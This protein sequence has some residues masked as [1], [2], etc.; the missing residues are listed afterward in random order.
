MK[1]IY[2]KGMHC[3]ACKKLVQMELEENGLLK[4]ISSL[5]L[6]PDNTGKLNITEGV[7]AQEKEKIERVINNMETYKTL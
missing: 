5:E 1:E 3:D 4:N 2:V 6:L 7:T